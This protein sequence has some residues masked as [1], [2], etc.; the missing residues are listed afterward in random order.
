MRPPRSSRSAASWPSGTVSAIC[1]GGP[2]SAPRSISWR[3]RCSSWRCLDRHSCGPEWE[4]GGVGIE[5]K[6]DRGALSQL[7]EIATSLDFCQRARHL[8]RAMSGGPKSPF[9]HWPIQHFD[10]LYGYAWYCGRGLIVS[11]L[12][13]AR[14]TAQ[15]AHAYHDFEEAMLERH[16]SDVAANGG[17]FVIHDWRAMGDYDAEARRVWQDRMQGREK[18]YL[19]GSVVCLIRA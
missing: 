13:V 17:I 14:G 3:A 6:S 15:A 8:G 9:A 5:R 7:V 1:A 4:P 19:R 11:H 16:A 12:T 2:I 10:R 18:G